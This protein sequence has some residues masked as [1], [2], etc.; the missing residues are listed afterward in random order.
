MSWDVPGS[1]V[2]KSPPSNTGDMAST[3]VEELASHMPWGNQGH[4]LQELWLESLCAPAKK[5]KWAI[6]PPKDMEE[7]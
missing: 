5:Q 6:M 1:P 3:P 4:A 2:V 7:P